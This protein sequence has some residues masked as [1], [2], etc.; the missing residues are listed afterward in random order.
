MPK[1]LYH[2]EISDLP[3]LR[4]LINDGAVFLAVDTECNK[5][6]KVQELGLASWIS[7]ES[8]T[9][10]LASVPKT[11]VACNIRLTRLQ[12]G[13]DSKP[14]AREEPWRPCLV[15]KVTIHQV[16]L[17]IRN[18]LRDAGQ[19]HAVLVGFGMFQELRALYE[20][21]PAVMAQFT[22]WLDVQ[23]MIQQTYLFPYQLYDPPPLQ[24]CTKP[25]GFLQ[26]HQPTHP[27][28]SAN[29]A[30]RTMTI[31]LSWISGPPESVAECLKHVDTLRGAGLARRRQQGETQSGL[32]FWEQRPRPFQKFSN[33][34]KLQMADHGC[35]VTMLDD[36]DKL[37][38]LLQ[39]YSPSAIGWAGPHYYGHRHSLTAHN[40]AKSQC[41]HYY[42]CFLTPED[43]RRFVAD[44]G[45]VM[46]NGRSVLIQDVSTANDTPWC[47]EELADH[48]LAEIRYQNE[49][50]SSRI[51]QKN[52]RASQAS[53]TVE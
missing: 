19:N 18:I 30:A 43:L 12:I 3:S 5:D 23:K 21:L 7:S 33:T 49:R 11:V 13:L 29:D 47:F 51:Q 16:E 32:K 17:E 34:V 40:I 36:P 24:A 20:N 45:S 31:L 27:H 9:P 38:D 53:R 50:K 52:K 42:V 2:Q 37:W 15:E 35:P 25:F 28:C 14:Q 8:R 26:G 10:V 41:G 1:E 4:S 39:P 44:Y 46:I 48:R 6:R 22:Y